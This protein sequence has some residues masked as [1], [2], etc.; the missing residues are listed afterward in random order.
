MLWQGALA[1]LMTA[2]LP[3]TG[4][5]HAQE[6]DHDPAQ[7]L[8]QAAPQQGE[9]CKD[10]LNAAGKAKFR[11]FTRARG[12]SIADRPAQARSAAC[13]SAALSRDGRAAQ[14]PRRRKKKGRRESLKAATTSSVGE[15][16]RHSDG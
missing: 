15:F 13:S 7:A 3:L 9:D 4:T 12:A 14:P 2:M 8:A 6:R 1:A 11:P 5:A 10:K 16:S